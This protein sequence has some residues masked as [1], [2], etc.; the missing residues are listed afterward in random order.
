MREKSRIWRKWPTSTNDGW[1]R[2]FQNLANV[3]GTGE[4]LDVARQCHLFFM[5]LELKDNELV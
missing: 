5:G 2:D 3:D 1:L 4:R